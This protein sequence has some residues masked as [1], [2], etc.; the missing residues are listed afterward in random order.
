MRIITAGSP[1]FKRYLKKIIERKSIQNEF[2]EKKV[3][4]ILKNV[5]MHGDRALVEYTKKFDNFN[6]Q[7][8]NLK[9]TKDEIRDTA[10]QIQGEIVESFKLA[11]FRIRE[12]QKRDFEYS[13]ILCQNEGELLGEIVKPLERV[14]I[15][16]P[17]G[18]NTY[19]ST[20]LMNVI[21]A[22]V[23]G[24]KEIVVVSPTPY[25]E[26]NPYLLLAAEIVGINSIY[27]IGGAQAIAALAYGT[28]WIPKVDKI[29]GPGNI[30]VA[31]AKRLVYGEVD[32]DMIAGPSEILI[33]SDGNSSPSF[34]AADLISQAEHDEMALSILITT[35]TIFA[36]QVKEEVRRRLKE[37]GDREIATKAI[38]RQGLIIVVKDLKEA[39]GIANEIAAEHL[40]L[41]V[42]KPWEWLGEVKNAG[43]VFLGNFTPEAFGDYLAGPNHT[44]P[45]GGTSRFFSPLSV[46]DFLKR[47]NYI[48]FSKEMLIRHGQNVINM[49]E[50]EGLKAHAESVN[51]RI[52]D[53]IS[54]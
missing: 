42:D 9:I 18:K 44:L 17:G 20:L 11:A 19:P 31:T 8:R 28:N 2:I 22:Q 38:E 37:I 6:L 10:S 34:I 52:K 50:A 3:K 32:I 1:N 16:V 25:G 45:T 47:T 40:E 21:P 51:V 43:A 41:A 23:A 49:A 48:Y 24:V 14:G 35:S 33:I 46:K 15:Y 5:R 26:I 13:W 53:F 12:F 7:K 36:S 54:K 39:L 30:F 29:V 4:S 27:R